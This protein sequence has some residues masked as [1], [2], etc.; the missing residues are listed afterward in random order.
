MNRVL[1]I[2]CGI[3]VL[4]ANG[5][6]QSDSSSP[7][8]HEPSSLPPLQLRSEVTLAPASLPPATSLFESG[9][10]GEQMSLTSK[11]STLDLEL[12][13]RLARGGYLTAPKPRSEHPFARSLDAIFE[14]E[15][16]RIGKTTVACS[17]V[18]AIKR[19]NPLCL[20]NPMFFNVSW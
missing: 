20:I 11:A 3:V 1:I 10:L 15:F 8:S 12:Y 4:C 2:S 5:F 6:S 9:R 13:E 7:P 16:I 19:K 18:T 14:P 17:I